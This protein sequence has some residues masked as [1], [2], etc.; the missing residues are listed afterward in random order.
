MSHTESFL[1]DLAPMHSWAVSLVIMFNS[2][3]RPQPVGRV[4]WGNDLRPLGH[5]STDA[6]VHPL[7]SN[8]QAMYPPRSDGT[9]SIF[10]AWSSA[11]RS[12]SRAGSSWDNPWRPA[13]AATTP[14][15]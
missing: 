11:W 3:A 13:R 2:T 6:D 7:H 10:P 9:P 15:S 4:W 5:R 8:R 1:A 14:F 12:V